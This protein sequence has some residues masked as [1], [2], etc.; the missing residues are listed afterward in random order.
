MHA[1]EFQ[2]TVHDGILQIPL[3]HQRQLNGR[4]VR[5]VVVDTKSEGTGEVETLFARLRRVRI[6]ASIKIPATWARRVRSQA[7][8]A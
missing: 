5:V 2:T 4:D 6:A 8:L 1:I 3:E 7:I